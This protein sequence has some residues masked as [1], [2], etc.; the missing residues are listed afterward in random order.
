MSDRPNHYG[1]LRG[2]T[3]TEAERA[4]LRRFCV[5]GRTGRPTCLEGLPSPLCQA[6]FTFGCVRA[7]LVGGLP[8]AA[9]TPRLERARSDDA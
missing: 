4:W 2:G 6:C 1:P 3:L 5:G 7:I 9:P 8:A